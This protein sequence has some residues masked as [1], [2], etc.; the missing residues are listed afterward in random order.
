MKIMAF[1]EFAD[2]KKKLERIR[3]RIIGKKGKSRE[4]IENL[5]ETHV[6]V[7]GKTV[8]IIGIA[9]NVTMARNAVEMFLEG[10]AHSAVYRRL[11]QF[12]RNLKEH[13]LS[14]I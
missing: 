2:K 4:I 11:E 10:A 12:R 9:E 5:T 13:K 6:S 8:S 7:Y 14:Y 3:G 1:D